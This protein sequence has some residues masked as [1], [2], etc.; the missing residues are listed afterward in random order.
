MNRRDEHCIEKTLCSE[1]LQCFQRTK[2][3]IEKMFDKIELSFSPYDTAWV[4][5]IP[6]PELPQAPCFPQCI[7]WLLDNQVNDGSWGLHN[8]PYWLVKD[9]VLCTL[10]CVLAL[11]RWG[12]GEEQMNKGIYNF[13]FFF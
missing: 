5:M 6:S 7:N 8:R 12:I 13:F 1:C 4:A 3:R 11:K 9:A 2:E 10:A